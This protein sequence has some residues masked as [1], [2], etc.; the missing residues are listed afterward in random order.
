[1]MKS[2]TVERLLEST[3]IEIQTSVDLVVQA[4]VDDKPIILKIYENGDFH[5]RVIYPVNFDSVSLVVNNEVVSDPTE[6]ANAIKMELEKLKND[7][8]SLVA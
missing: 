3:P 7:V 6:V 1:M 8:A 5:Y 2:K 4:M